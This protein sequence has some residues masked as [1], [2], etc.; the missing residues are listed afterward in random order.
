MA[1]SGNDL[2]I[3]ASLKYSCLCIFSSSSATI[4]HVHFLKLDKYSLFLFLFLFDFLRILGKYISSHKSI[5]G[6]PILLAPFYYNSLC[7]VVMYVIEC[8]INFEK[9]QVRRNEI[10]RVQVLTG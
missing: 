4:V 1:I 8:T 2:Y 5:Q 10:R 6:S 9:E 7:P 3:L